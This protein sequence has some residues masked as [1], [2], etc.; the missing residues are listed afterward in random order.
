LERQNGGR[1]RLSGGR[2]RVAAVGVS[3]PNYKA[4]GGISAGL[5]LMQRVASH[6]DA[7]MY[8][9]ADRDEDF[10]QGRLAVA[11]RRPVNPLSA[12]AFMLPR[13]VTT[14][15]WRPRIEEWLQTRNP[16]IVHIHN[17]HPAGALVRVA[18][19]CARMQIPYVISTHG[20]VEFNDFSKGFGSPAWQKPLLERF[21][22][23]PLVDVARNAAR[24]LMLSPFEEP[25]LRGMGVR[26]DRL[27]VVPN[28]VDPYFL[29]R[30]NDAERRRL[31]SRFNLPGD[32]P[33][34]L[35]VGN[36]TVN[37][38]LDVL[39]RSLRMMQ[40]RAVAVIAGAI[41]SKAENERLILSSGL[42][43]ADKR[44][45]FTD[46]I[47]KEELRA[48]YRSVDV[49]AFPSRADTLPLVILEAMASE[50]PVVAT[51]IGGIPY[52]VTPQEGILVPPGDP[53]RL[54]QA[55][56]RACADAPMRASMGASGRRRVI[57]H[58]DWQVSARL[59]IESYRAVIAPETPRC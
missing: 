40:Q 50:L 26:E 39:L 54:A 1:V 59:A 20:F 32:C 25:M 28:G 27:S 22:R 17:P 35:F 12:L 41:R 18:N 30:P 6:C 44:F 34:L 33:L 4:S 38:G 48:L 53:A 15:A 2:I 46:F 57:G 52:E 49:F 42:G 31:V 8:V 5:Q 24:I 13:Q 3:P 7:A 9:M 11:L 45:L 51:H 21:V 36:H 47:T 56:D 55:L 19:A 43:L 58:F 16:H 14:M 37:K 29:E 23:R 10:E